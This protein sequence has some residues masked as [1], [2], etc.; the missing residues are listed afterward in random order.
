MIKKQ[1]AQEGDTQGKIWALKTLGKEATKEGLEVL[2]DT[3]KSAP[4]WGIRAEAAT[5]LGE[6]RTEE[7]LRALVT[8]LKEEK[9]SKVRTRICSALGEYRDE[10]AAQALT[11]TLDKDSSIFAKGAAAQS[12]GKTKSPMAFEKLK[13]ALSIKSW[14]DWVRAQAFSGLRHLR[15]NRA[16]ELFL[17][18]SRYGS[19]KGARL[20]AVTALGEYGLEQKEVTETLERYLEDPYIR[21]RF[22]AADALA[23][24]KD[25]SAL[26]PL[27]DSAYRIV[28]GHLK[29][30][31]F[32][33]ARRLRDNLR[34][35]EELQSLKESL[36]KIQDDNRKLKERIQKLEG[37]TK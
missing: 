11:E 5:A 27:E 34:K 2:I 20:A 3:L 14:N 4:F 10:K 17:D 9:R 37:Q 32:R 19:P 31:A 28:D 16:L 21:V 12:L 29:T 24:R 6:T 26:G 1:M 22:F 30:A 8:A 18:G 23:K 35:P 13:T 15:D 33:A 7:G 36:E 25:P